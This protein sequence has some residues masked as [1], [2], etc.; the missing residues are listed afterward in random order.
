M[1]SFAI[2]QPKGICVSEFYK[3]HLEQERRRRRR[4][5]PQSY[6][7]W[8]N[9]LHED[10]RYLFI[11]CTLRQL[12]TQSVSQGARAAKEQTQRAVKRQSENETT[13]KHE[14]RT[15]QSIY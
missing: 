12:N 9:N 15:K 6:S 13:C 5:S 11:Y 7:L 14:T 3:G 2:A 8:N 1:C 4:R 10:N